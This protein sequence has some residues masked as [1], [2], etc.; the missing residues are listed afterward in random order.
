ML[1]VICAAAWPLMLTSDVQLTNYRNPS[2]KVG[3]GSG[4]I[5]NK[6]CKCIDTFVSKL[7]TLEAACLEWGLPARETLRNF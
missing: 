1:H 7:P 6:H 3:L 2:G 5:L 4:I